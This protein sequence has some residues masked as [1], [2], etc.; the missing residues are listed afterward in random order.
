MKIIHNYTGKSLLQLREQFG[1]GKKGFYNNDWW[2]KDEFAKETPKKGTY[3]IELHPEWN[4]LNCQEQLDKIGDE[5]GFLHPA[6]LA[7]AILTHYKETN[8]RLMDNWFSRT[9]SVDSSGR[10]VL[11]GYFDS[12]GLYVAYYWGDYRVSDIGVASARKLNLKPRTLEPFES[13]LLELENFK[14]KVEKV[15]KQMI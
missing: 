2:L 10:R 9:C 7:E 14:E 1:V 6:V 15:L 11:V 12:V 13:R 5:M 3:E 8:E 4:N